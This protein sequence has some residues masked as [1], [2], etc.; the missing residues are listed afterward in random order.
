MSGIDW[1]KSA[2]STNG[3]NGIGVGLVGV[4]WIAA[5]ATA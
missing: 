3:G 4:S 2:R 1:R 5:A